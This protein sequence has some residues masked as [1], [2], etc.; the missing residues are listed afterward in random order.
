MDRSLTRRALAL[1]AA[2][3]CAGWPLL[4][5]HAWPDRP[6]TL[7]VPN[8]AGGAADNLARGIAEEMSKRL[9]QQVVVENTAGASGAIGAQRVLRAAPDGYTL[10]FG[11][12]SDLVVTPVANRSAG[13]A[14]KDFTPIA[15]VGV[16]PMALVARPG[17]GVTDV[18][19]LIAMARAKPGGITVGTTGLT[20]FQAFATVALQ[21][22]AGIDLLAVPYKGGA[23]LL[24][25]LLGGQVDLAVMALPGAMP[26]VRSGKLALL[27]L[28]IEQR[29][30]S[31]SDLPTINEG[32]TVKGVSMQIWAGLAGPS[33]MP[34]PVAERLNGVVREILLDKAFNEARIRKGDQPVAPM[35]TAE[36]GRFLAAET[37]KYRTL[38]TGMRLE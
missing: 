23:P 12:T 15:L 28:L 37:D 25:D 38:A 1:F 20:S 21:R 8:P 26:H 9:G 11:T 17:L 5:A 7:V 4:P 33:G 34:G 35:T 24:T 2:L 36:F 27:G 13:Y 14:P 22:A 18:D 10:L 19:Q 3:A 31:S 29:L 16:T 6:I 30:P 32:R